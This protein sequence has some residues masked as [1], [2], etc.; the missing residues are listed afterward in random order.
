MFVGQALTADGSCRKA[1]AAAV[2]SRLLDGAAIS[3]ADTGAYCKAWARMSLATLAGL[4]RELGEELGADTPQ[5]RQWRGR[6]ICLV[7]D[8]LTALGRKQRNMYVDVS[9]G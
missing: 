2:A 1:V 6:R 9:S 7:D 3:C 4:T 5:D 8:A